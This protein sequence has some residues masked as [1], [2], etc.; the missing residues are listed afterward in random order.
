MDATG[1]RG[2]VRNGGRLEAVPHLPSP[3]EAPERNIGG[4]DE[5]SAPAKL[6]P[7]D[8]LRPSLTSPAASGI[9]SL[10]VRT[11]DF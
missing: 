8:I 10:S 5:P 2:A 1:R 4:S 3:V 11:G 6:I 9:F 7:A